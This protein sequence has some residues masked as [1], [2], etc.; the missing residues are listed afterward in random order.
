MA[1]RRKPAPDYT[2][3][4]SRSVAEAPFQVSLTDDQPV[5]RY[6]L[7]DRSDP[8]PAMSNHSGLDQARFSQPR[9][10]KTSPVRNPSLPTV[11]EATEDGSNAEDGSSISKESMS[12]GATYVGQDGAYYDESKGYSGMEPNPK[13]AFNH[14]TLPTITS[15][16]PLQWEYAQPAPGDDPF[17]DQRQYAQPLENAPNQT[18]APPTYPYMH[19]GSSW[20]S[21]TRPTSAYST[22]SV[23]LSSQPNVTG[24]GYQPE[25]DTTYTGSRSTIDHFQHDTEAYASGAYS[26]AS[27]RPPRSRS[28]TPAVDDEDYHIVGNG[29][30]H[31][32][33]HSPN[34]QPQS[35]DY[36]KVAL[37]EQDLSYHQHYLT[38]DGDHESLYTESEKTSL[39]SGA[40]PHLEPETPVNTRHF[41]PAPMGRILRRHKTKKRV[42]LTN[43]NL[44]V[45]LDVPPKLV[46][47]RKGE[48]EMMKTR[49]TAVTG[50]P[51][52]FEKNGFFLRQ[53]ESG[54]TTELFIVITMYNEDEVLFCRTMYGVMQ[55][56]SHLCSR[57]HSRIWGQDAWKKVVVCIVADGRKK[58]HPRVLDCLT[59]LGV[60]Q[61]GDHMKNMVNNKPVT[62]HLFEYTA[63]FG[64][65]PNLHFKY[66]DKGIVPTQILFC[67]K[68]RNQK[69]INS[70]RWFFNAFG[71]MLQPNVCVLLDVGTRPGPKSIYH[72]WKAFDLNSNVAGACGEIAAYKGKHWSAL[73]NPLVAAQNFEYKIANILDKPTES[74]FG[75]ISVLPGAFSAYRYIALQNNKQGKGPLA[76]Y[77]KGEVLH[78]RDTD[79]FT[80]NMYL[81]EDRILCFELVAK[82]NS[83]WILKYV[84]SAI[85]ETDVPDALPE[86]ISQRRR[87]LNGSFFAATY[88]IAHLGQ[89]LHSGH[90]IGRKFML[91]METIYNVINLIAAWFAIGNFYLFFIILTSSLETPS[92]GMTGLKYFNAVIQFVMGGIVVGCFLFSMGNK[93]KASKWKYK[94][95]AIMLSI[96]MVYLLFSAVMVAVEA[97]GSG[98]V[99]YT[100]MVF[101]IS[102]TYGV[103]VLSSFLALDPWHIFTS[104]IPYLLLSPTYINI[105]NIYAFSN[106]DDISWG[107]KQDTE[108]ESD[109][110]AVIQNSNSQVDVEVLTDA[111]DVNGMYE[112]SLLNLKHKK[113]VPKS[114][115][116]NSLAE[117]EQAA[118]DY[119]ANVRTNVLLSWVLSNALLLVAILGGGD[120]VSTFS[121]N[122]SF[123]R[124]KAYMTFILA[125]VAITTSIRFS[126]STMYLIA[127]VFTG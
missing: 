101:S 28:P 36:E 17:V 119:Y 32:T 47:P 29:S 90:S 116:G 54:R 95:S 30:V 126:G 49:Y 52:D 9:F 27:Y 72:L 44:V 73:L 10:S 4:S 11:A 63:S 87:W 2:Q 8:A 70:H 79:I 84:K 21:P 103:Y 42:Q 1:G 76:S 94:L 13:L 22:T 68:E 46:L 99:A 117:K 110:G 45:D 19:T 61:P 15:G 31:Y 102:V 71:P 85:A 26:R 75:Y 78:G 125:F 106:L 92:F 104:F 39:S 35:Y 89:I 69:K 59:L 82:A 118:K 77:F 48:A 23:G 3:V 124:T 6:T 57:K 7:T 98:G 58:V 122:S 93:P 80:S 62:A 40:S 25:L 96:M 51:N 112:E 111:A 12:S 24:H 113:P 20:Q 18:Y 38:Y 83:N 43:G 67:M 5:V 60:Y 56:I 88:A 53:N 121:D 120:A 37:Q 100:T 109:L 66:P 123:S 114:S 127:R 115:T 33:G 14:N 108:L 74:L 65:D 50:D 107:T 91:I 55:N 97:A 16:Q 86:F 105:L 34:R 64:L 41:G 81:A